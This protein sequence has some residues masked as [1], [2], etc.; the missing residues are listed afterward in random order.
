M[1][2]LSTLRS[3]FQRVILA[4]AMLCTLAHGQRYTL[5]SGTD[6]LIFDRA[7][8]ISQVAENAR[9]PVNTD[10]IVAGLNEGSLDLSKIKAGDIFRKSVKEGEKD[11]AWN[12]IDS[13][14]GAFSAV[15][16]STYLLV[17]VESPEERVMLLEASGH[18][19]SYVNGEPRMGDAYGHG[20]MVLPVLIRK[21]ENTLL[22]AHAGRGTMR[23]ALT[24]PATQ[25]LIQAQDLTLPDASRDREIDAY[26]GVPLVNATNVAKTVVL[27]TQAGGSETVSDAI[28]L[29]P[30]SVLKASARVK[31][32]KVEGRQSTEGGETKESSIALSLKVT[33]GDHLLTEYTGSLRAPEKGS[34]Y[35]V[36][37]DSRIDA[38]AQYVAIVPA[39][40][41]EGA[42]SPGLVL[43]LH[44]ASV[45]ATS[46]AGS[47]AP[48]TGYLIACPTNR[49][50]FGFDWEDWGRIDALEAMDLVKER[51]K[52]DPQ[53]Q[54]LTG[55]SMGG[56]GTWNI[57]VLYP[58]RFAAI[59][60]SAGWLSFDTYTSR[61]GPKYAPEGALGDLF[62]ESRASSDTLDYFKN[63]TGKG[64]FILHGDKDDNV[65]VEQARQAREALDALGITYKHHEQVGAGHWWDDD[66][67]GAAC[68]D[69][70]GIWEVFD[71]HRLND[72]NTKPLITPP[73]DER[74]FS[75]NAFKRVFDKRFVLVYSTGGTEAENAWSFAKARFD[76]EQWWYR[77]NG[78]AIMMSDA[79][80]LARKPQCNVIMYG[81]SE[82]LVGWHNI[83]GEGVVIARGRVEVGIKDKA[84]S[85]LG[86]DFGV[87]AALPRKGMNGFEVG[88][89]GG[90]GIR[91]MKATERL[92]YFSSGVGYP[93]VTILR[94]SIWKD[95]FTG[96]AGAGT[97]EKM[98]WN[99]VD[100]Q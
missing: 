78:Q 6:S 1:Y 95:G 16:R 85:V 96:V 53:R 31:I 77:G 28:T 75:L 83:V 44:G 32:G 94:S 62:R 13:K 55:H 63:L 84:K 93:E 9:R 72:T 3:C 29:A 15:G 47:Y 37:F 100:S 98:E 64:I 8:A 4:S 24:K 76:A 2:E 45:E 73:V 11:V 54:Y 39:I 14:D 79:D 58:E 99:A 70:P 52:T 81:H 48:R 66:K 7:L 68:L 36:T 49:R 61:N 23:A 22:F 5:E 89:V 86:D 21:G 56:H 74:G 27:K 87:L 60:P 59:A 35:K 33:E 20:Y 80:F 88:V 34:A 92:G 25:V 38:S 17:Q 30:C 69:W 43:S 65:P 12:V 46:Q 10:L 18:G 90:S 51:Y 50:P 40:E 26:V 67:P 82:S 91:G 57:G 19:V 42:A 97:T 71:A 41:G